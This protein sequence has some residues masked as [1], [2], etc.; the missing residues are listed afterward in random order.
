MYH[1]VF[2]KLISLVF[3]NP[4]EVMYTYRA[5]EGEKIKEWGLLEFQGSF[6]TLGNQPMDRQF[7]GD[8]NFNNDGTP[9]FIVG[10]HILFGEEVKLPKPFAILQK[11][12]DEDSKHTK[13]VV[14][15]VIRR[16]ILFKTRPKPII[17]DPINKNNN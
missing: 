10:H 13:Y 5:E 9:F 6:S 7:I 2:V 8:L 11:V 3:L 1:I 16:K 4:D 14:P 15:A 12:I 17:S